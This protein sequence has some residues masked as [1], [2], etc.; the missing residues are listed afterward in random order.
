MT[1]AAGGDY[2]VKRPD[3]VHDGTVSVLVRPE[4]IG[5]SA[6]GSGLPATIENVVYSGEATVAHL[7]LSSGEEIR[8][9]FSNAPNGDGALPGKGSSVSL[10]LAPGAITVL[11]D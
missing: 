2:A 9:R 3:G 10:A 1:L 8:A 7:A 11:R 4:H 5:L 6:N